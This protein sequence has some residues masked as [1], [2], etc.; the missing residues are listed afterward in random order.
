MEIFRGRFD[1][2]MLFL[3]LKPRQV[4]AV[5][6]PSLSGFPLVW[7][8]SNPRVH[9]HSQAPTGFPCCR[10]KAERLT[11]RPRC[12][13]SCGTSGCS[14]WRFIFQV[15]MVKEK[16][17]KVHSGFRVCQTFTKMLYV[18]QFFHLPGP[19]ALPSWTELSTRALR[20]DDWFN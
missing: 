14:S 1:G 20:V 13:T 9:I 3:L 15:L 10:S 6:I 11:L 4:S 18:N 17:G 8:V 16:R 12:H 19:K 2:P 5:I 7:H